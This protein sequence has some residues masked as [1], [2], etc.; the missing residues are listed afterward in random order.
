MYCFFVGVNC[1]ILGPLTIYFSIE[2]K[3]S[4][5]KRSCFYYFFKIIPD[6]D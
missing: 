6:Y 4:P 2:V 5:K 3:K 1:Y